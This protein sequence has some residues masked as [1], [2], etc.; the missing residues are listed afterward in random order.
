MS[1]KI[2]DTDS[3][4]YW[5]NA[6]FAIDADGSPNAYAPNNKGLDWTANAGH[7]GHW[8]GIVTDSNGNPI[9]QG[10]NDPSPGFYVSPTALA[11]KSKQS[12]D[13]NRYVDSESINYISVPSDIVHNNG[14]KMG[15]VCVIYNKETDK[16]CAAICADAGPHNKP[17]EGSIAAA[18]AIGIKNVSPRNGGQSSGVTCL[19]FKNSSKGWPRIPAEMNDQAEALLEAFGGIDK[20]K[21]QS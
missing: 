6:P 18:T 5:I 9:I 19:I 11:D 16:Y 3:Y 17:G 15:D 7:D 20:L 8:F 14:I 13:L 2:V 1:I 4:L 10:P 21:S 12:H